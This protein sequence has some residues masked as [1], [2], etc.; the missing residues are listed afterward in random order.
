M[1]N[2]VMCVVSERFGGAMEKLGED[3]M[4]WYGAGWGWWVAQ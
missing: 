2:D 4:C 1:E 3:G